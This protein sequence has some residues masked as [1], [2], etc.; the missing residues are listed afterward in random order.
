MSEVKSVD[1]RGLIDSY[2][3]PCKLP[4]TGQELLIKP[5]T[6]GQ[7]KKIL[8]YEDEND[9]YVIEEALDKLVS[10]CVLTEDFNI[11]DLY[12][13]D[14]FFLLLEI[15][16][17]TKGSSYSFS[18][19]CPECNVDNLKSF[20]LDDLVSKEKDVSDYIIKINDGL[21]L[22]I[23]FPTRKNQ[24]DAIIDSNERGFKD[25]EREIEVIT[26][27]FAGCIKKAHIKNGIIDEISFSDRIYLLDN[28]TSD[29]FDEFKSWFEEN[30]FGVDFEILV[31]CAHCDFEDKQKIPLSDFFV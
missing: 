1:I 12:L 13:Q 3:F 22:E 18:F 16:K 20:S 26:S 8:V 11:D 21:K 23:D 4:G 15:R 6:T 25:K 29:K 7:M 31:S 30:E 24:K 28:I 17:I 27:T 14:R 10:D 9:P 5:I 19:K 2:E